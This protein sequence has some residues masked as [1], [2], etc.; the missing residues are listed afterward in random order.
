M[1][2][3]ISVI[4]VL[5]LSIAGFAESSDGELGV[6]FD[7]SYWSKWL[8][9][10]AEGYGQQGA[11]FKTVDVDLYGSGFVF[12]QKS[13]TPTDLAVPSTIGHT[14]LSASQQSWE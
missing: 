6:T 7:L 9:K 2:K 11:L 8:S 12:P 4:I 3:G 14:L 1:K 10:G 13:P 5:V